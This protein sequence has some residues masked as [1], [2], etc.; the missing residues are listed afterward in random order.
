T[1]GFR[2]QLGPL[3]GSVFVV[4]LA[5]TVMASTPVDWSQPPMACLED[6]VPR[7]PDRSCP[8][9][10]LVA[11]PRVDWPTD[12]SD[13]E[14]EYWRQRPQGVSH[15]RSVEIMRREELQPGT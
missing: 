7:P 14:R 9:L 15:C 3:W 13:E 5:G 2:V 1:H 12:L 10:T 11:D 6:M 8:D 4:L